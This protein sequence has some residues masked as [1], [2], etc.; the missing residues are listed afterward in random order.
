MSV[1]VITLDTLSYLTNKLSKTPV[2]DTCSA[3]TLTNKSSD[4]NGTSQNQIPSAQAIANVF[5]NILFCT[6]TVAATSSAHADVKSFVN[7]VLTVNLSLPRGAAGPRGLQGEQGPSGPS[8]P[9]GETGDIGPIGPSGARGPSG[10]QG[11]PGPTGPSGPRGLQG[12]SGPSGPRGLVGPTGPSGPQGIPGPSG[13]S[14]PRGLQ[15]LSGPS[16]PQGPQG[17]S[18]PRGLQGDPGPSGPSGPRGLQGPSG[19]SGPQGIPGPSGPSGPTGA[20]GYLYRP[21]INT[22]SGNVVFTCASTAA[23]SY[24]YKFFDAT[25]PETPVNSISAKDFL[26]SVMSFSGGTLTIN[27]AS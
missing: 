16:G 25:L 17:P 2:Q 21:S 6:T 7:G 1:K 4:I 19:P 11:A 27:L 9:K 22:A 13:P 14:G 26:A 5:N 23:A 20:R 12:P 15:G 8:G 24:Q 3:Y 18:G 10:P